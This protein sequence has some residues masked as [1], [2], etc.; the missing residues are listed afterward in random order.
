M[1]TA[2]T[3]P[4]PRVSL[5]WNPSGS[6]GFLGSFLGDRKTVI[7]G[8]FA[9]VYDRS[10]TVQSVEIPMLGIGYGET[11]TIATPFCNATGAGGATGR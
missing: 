11:V 4:A 8:G 2:S 3:N 1:V 10:N 5:A 7:R 9:M 6:K